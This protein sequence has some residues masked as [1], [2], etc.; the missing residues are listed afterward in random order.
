MGRG[1][2]ESHSIKWKG[3]GNVPPDDR[4]AE[5]HLFLLLHLNPVD[6]YNTPPVTALGCLQG[7]FSSFLHLILP[8]ALGG[9][10]SSSPHRID[11]QTVARSGKVTCLSKATQHGRVGIG[12]LGQVC[13][14]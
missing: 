11:E 4:K 6:K 12:I 14:P 7:A 8:T 13:G 10:H 5:S 3:L 1:L 9:G 2:K